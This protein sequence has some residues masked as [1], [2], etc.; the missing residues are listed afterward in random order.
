MKLADVIRLSK[1]QADGSTGEWFQTYYGLATIPTF[2]PPSLKNPVRPQIDLPTDGWHEDDPEHLK[3]R[4]KEDLA[5]ILKRLRTQTGKPEV[6]QQAQYP[7]FP[8]IAR[9]M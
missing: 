3:K 4:A 7:I 1:I 2:H 9:W 6:T 5:E 8:N